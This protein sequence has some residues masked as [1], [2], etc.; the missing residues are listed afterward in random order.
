MF[1]HIT[2][3]TNDSARAA[4]FYDT[5]LAILRHQRFVSSNY[6]A[7]YGLPNGN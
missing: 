1:S 3:G 5:V 7:G 6:H 4:A 2:V